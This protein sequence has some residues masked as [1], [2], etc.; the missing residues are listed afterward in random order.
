MTFCGLRSPAKYHTSTTK[1]PWKSVE[2]VRIEGFGYYPVGCNFKRTVKSDIRGKAN[3]GGV[4]IRNL[5]NFSQIQ[6]AALGGKFFR[7]R[8]HDRDG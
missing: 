1:R 5:D 2:C 4:D 8:F 6:L 7:F 3:F